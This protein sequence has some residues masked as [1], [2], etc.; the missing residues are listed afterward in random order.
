MRDLSTWISSARRT[1]SNVVRAT[2]GM[3]L[4]VLASSWRINIAPSLV[5]ELCDMLDDY[6]RTVDALVWIALRR[7]YPAKAHK[8]VPSHR[9]VC[10][11]S[12]VEALNVELDLTAV[13]SHSRSYVTFCVSVLLVQRL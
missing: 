11:R 9:E 6:G 10:I 5:G 7:S 2:E 13:E 4:D 12:T 3:T 8:A 1:A